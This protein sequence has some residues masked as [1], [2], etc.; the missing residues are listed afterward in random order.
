MPLA[1]RYAG[2][3][4][5]DM[6]GSGRHD[7]ITIWNAA[8]AAVDSEQLV[9]Q[10]LSVDA[11]CLKICD[12][13]I[14]L[15]DASHIEIVG[16]GKA[17]PGMA[18]GLEQILADLPSTISWSGWINVPD[19][20]VDTLNQIRLHGARPAGLNEPT[21]AGV[22]GTTE[23]L[24]RVSQLS[25]QDL[26]LVLIS[27]GGSALLPAPVS[28][29]SLKDKLSVTQFLAA[30]GATIQE[31]N[32]VRGRISAVK[33]GGLARACTANRLCT[34]IISDVIGD[35][36]DV[37]ASGPTC[38]IQTTTGLGPL[39]VLR[40]F[41]PDL[42]RVPPSVVDAIRKPVD[43]TPPSC[44]VEN[45]I[46]G[47]NQLAVAAAARSATALGYQVESWGSD[48]AGS[49]SNLG[50]QLY[51]RMQELRQ[52]A[53]E[54]GHRQCLLAGGETTVQLCDESIRGRGGRNQEVVLGALAEHLQFDSWDGL[55]LLSAGTDGEDGPTPSAG[56]LSDAS[57]AA[58]VRKAGVDPLDF[59]RT[60]NAW[61]F[62]D[63]FDGLVNTGPTHTN[64]MDVQVGLIHP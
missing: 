11:H 40:R 38:T 63:Q 46:I 50:R 3:Q 49:A 12:Q 31:L 61:P 43:D 35:P 22:D 25:P 41:D 13:Q 34:L 26:C 60:N 30:A 5:A 9:R 10:S 15:P 64:V 6:S 48:N 45:H 16:A 20:C 58:A 54:T 37:I 8:V 55:T 2:L 42:T 33:N 7:A 24:R 14:A 18:R 32:A 56:A 53:T 47:N 52:R 39:E 21:Q 62:F 23:I 17:G 59:L 29:I 36:L 27:G 28:R 44:V 57:L 51:N 19:D 1:I 4:H